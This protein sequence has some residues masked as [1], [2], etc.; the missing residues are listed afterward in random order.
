[1]TRHRMLRRIAYV[2]RNR[3]SALV[4]ALTLFILLNPLLAVSAIGGSMLGVALFVVLVLAVWALRLERPVLWGLGLFG[5][6]TID[7]LI[8]DRMGFG[9]LLPKG[10]NVPVKSETTTGCSHRVSCWVGWI[11]ARIRTPFD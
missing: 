11:Y 7:A 4:V 5:F 8:A 2:R 10:A 6:I 1:M 3:C 9:G